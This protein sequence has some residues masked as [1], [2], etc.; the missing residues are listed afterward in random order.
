MKKFLVYLT[1]FLVPLIII[2]YVADVFISRYLPKQN[3]Y[4]VGE[5]PVWSDLFGGRVNSDIVIYGNSRAW[6]QFDPNIISD[7]LTTTAYNLGIDGYGFDMQYLRHS[8]LLQYNKKPKLIIQ[9]VDVFTLEK[10]TDLYNDDQFLPY[11]LFNKEIKNVTQNY[12]IYNHWDY[13]IPLVRYYGK[14]TAIKAALRMLLFP[15]NNPVMRM[16]GYQGQDKEWNNDF[17]EAKRKIGS[18]K[19]KTDS[20]LKRL[21]EKYLKECQRDHLNMIFVYAPV[22]IE[23]QKFISNGGE[24]IDQ[25]KSYSK[26]YKIPFYDFSNDSISFQ[27]NLFYN[28]MHLN[29]KGSVL[30][31]NQL[32]KT[33]KDNHSLD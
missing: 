10:R 18:Y 25:Y 30:F 19:V 9:S 27:K 5:F 22:Y 32:V 31:T 16:N 28:A 8:I 26:K 11:M 21:F 15:S 20:A 33:L 24:I 3:D 14:N 13:E 17:D 4:A 12:E 7:S 23:G 1:W 6:V 29:K 2:A